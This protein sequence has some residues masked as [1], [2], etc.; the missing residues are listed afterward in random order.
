MI[1]RIGR[2]G[3]ERQDR[4]ERTDSTGRKGQ[5]EHDGPR[6]EQEGWAERQNRQAG[7]KIRTDRKDRKLRKDRG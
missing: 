3:Q 5:K 2:E 1:G 7:H 4:K 6:T